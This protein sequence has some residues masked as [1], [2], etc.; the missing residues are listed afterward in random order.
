MQIICRRFNIPQIRFHDLR[1]AFASIALD[2]GINIEVVSKILG[3]A[4]TTITWD[5]YVHLFPHSQTQATEKLNGL[6]KKDDIC[7]ISL[8]MSIANV[9]Y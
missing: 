1:H 3:H 5:T 6:F 7:N 4:S 9:K 8:E 2:R